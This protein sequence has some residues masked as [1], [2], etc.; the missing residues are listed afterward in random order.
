MRWSGKLGAGMGLKDLHLLGAGEIARMIREGAVTSVEVVEACLARIREVDGQVQAWTF[1]DPE[2]AVAQARA[3]VAED[4]SGT[5]I[6][7]PQEGQAILR[8][9]RLSG[10]CRFFLQP[11]HCKRVITLL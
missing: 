10:I 8:P 2:Y 7:S 4:I 5:F 6:F 3:A 11:E 1:L 9:A